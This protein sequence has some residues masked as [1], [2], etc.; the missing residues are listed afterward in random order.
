MAADPTAPAIARG[1]AARLTFLVDEPAEETVDRLVGT[2]TEAQAHDDLQTQCLVGQE[3]AR[4]L[5]VVGRLDE[6]RELLLE[7][8]KL[9]ALESSN[10]AVLGRSYVFLAACET[11]RGDTKKG[12]DLAR[13][14][15]SLLERAPTLLEAEARLILAECLQAAGRKP[16]AAEALRAAERSCRA[17]PATERE[18]M[19]LWVESLGAPADPVPLLNL[20]RREGHTLVWLEAARR[21]G[22]ADPE[23]H[24]ALGELDAALPAGLSLEKLVVPSGRFQPVE[25]VTGILAP[26][27]EAVADVLQE[28]ISETNLDRLFEF[29]LDALIRT[30]EAEAGYL[31]IHRQ[32]EVLAQIGRDRARRSVPPEKMKFSTCVARLALNSGRVIVADD[33]LEDPILSNFSSVRQRRIRSVLCVPLRAGDVPMGAVYLEHALEGGVF[34]PPR[35]ELAKI[36]AR[37]AAIAV[38]RNVLYA[39]AIHD[40]LTGLHNFGYLERRLHRGCREALRSGRPLS[41]LLLDLD[42]F[43]QLNEAM[44]HDAGNDVLKEVARLIGACVRRTDVVAPASERDED[45]ESWIC[46]RMGGD[47]F[48]VLLPG[49]DAGGAA[50]VAERLLAAIRRASFGP[51]ERPVRLSLSIGMATMPQDAHEARLLT[52]RADE[53]L[54]RAKQA[55]KNRAVGWSGTAPTPVAPRAPAP[56]GQVRRAATAALV[57]ATLEE[58]EQEPARPSGSPIV[59]QSA[60]MRKVLGLVDKTA[61]SDYPVVI[62]GETGTGKE[63]VAREIHRL[64]ARR[65][66]PFI[67]VNCAAVPE[68]LLESE[69]FGHK[70][71]AFTGADR[72]RDGLFKL[73]DGGTLFLD[74]VG[75][76]SEALQK[77]LLRVLQEGE[78][79]PVGSQQSVRVDVRVVAATQ[80]DLAQA[81]SRGKFREDLYYR[82]RVF[83]V[84]L[85][86]LRER[87]E[88]LPLLINHLLQQIAL[89]TR[90]A[91]RRV[92][93]EAMRILLHHAW[94]GNVR[95]LLNT[96]KLAAALSDAEIQTKDLPPEVLPPDGPTVL[97]R[98]APSVPTNVDQMWRVLVEASLKR[99]DFNVKATAE[100]LGISRTTLYA[101]MRKLGIGPVATEESEPP[102]PPA[103]GA[104]PARPG[105]PDPA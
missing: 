81:I 104:P 59:G 63:L 35:V 22:A 61:D 62:Q 11:R 99:N 103:A 3:L 69:L 21:L 20:L 1:P 26:E 79:R 101:R 38:E 102:P 50:A 6:S 65:T 67:D 29:I 24:R 44:G 93:R 45:G 9:A 98:A 89:E 95:E 28:L 46:G 66:G 96:L 58:H 36:L 84:Y 55:G 12:C 92:S 54:S 86:A 7:S 70:R 77:K 75:E 80:Q 91:P 88:D 52:I 33:A 100:E 82:L 15:L 37:H 40:T 13:R 17:T 23:S 48:G 47:E 64:S 5:M 27:L 94:P 90:T 74:E 43:K 85:P 60:A 39:Q 10:R 68:T 83:R 105:S 14:G 31:L 49:A 30:C 2:A 56:P 78:F 25:P 18:R 57:R 8:R 76:M 41:F 71:G 72:D 42:D 34:T 97:T 19:R 73:A 53:A 4:A 16:E 51:P 32:G 87:R